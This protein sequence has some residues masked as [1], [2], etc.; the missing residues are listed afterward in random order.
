[1][2]R[3][4]LSS[5]VAAATA[6]V[7]AAGC[8]DDGAGEPPA[9]ILTGC[10][11]VPGQPIA[12]GGYY[13]DGNTIC[14]AAGQA[15]LF[16]GVDR[17]SLEWTTT[18]LH[19]SISD[20]QQMAAWNANVVRI[21]LNQDF[22]LAASPL[23]DAAYAGRV[24]EAIGWAEGAGIDVILDLHWS[25]RGVLGSCADACQQRMADINS[26]TFW[27]EVAARYKDDGRVLFELY[28]EPHNVTWPVWKSGGL[29]VDDYEAV[30]MQ[31]LYAAVRATG[32]QNLVIVGGL[33]WA[34]DLW[35]C[36]TTG[37]TATTSFTPPTSTA[38]PLAAARSAGT[39]SGA[40]S[41]RPIP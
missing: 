39:S 10:P 19:L 21:A 3:D 31:Q 22:W 41:A 5:M 29:T 2:T 11:D 34:Y 40:S 27:S 24:D 33:D 32:A 18:G 6:L 25:D 1:M 13:V 38:T 23:H 35:G 12:P 4:A 7:L 17:P 9:T 16:H 20:F 30:G 26:L 14:T 36:P 15:H 37:S 28:N 8:G